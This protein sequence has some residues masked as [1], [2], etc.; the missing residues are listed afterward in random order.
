MFEVTEG[1]AFS[2]GLS[3]PDTPA[4]TVRDL[5]GALRAW[6]DVG[7][8]EADRLHR[9]SKIAPRVVVYAHKNAAQLALR[10]STERIHRIEM[11]EL[12]AV[13]SHWLAEIAPHLTRRMNFSLTVAA[14]HVYLSLGAQT[15]DSVIERVGISQR[16]P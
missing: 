13:D 4:I 12:Y 11:L 7:S 6:V 15:S 9:A 14:R 8:P 2:K 10:Y 3:E 5:T 1:I 16:A